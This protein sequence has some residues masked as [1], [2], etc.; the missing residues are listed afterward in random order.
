LARPPDASAV[1]DDPGLADLLVIAAEPAW[2]ATNMLESQR[3]PSAR[4]MD[5]SDLSSEHC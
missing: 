1:P 3:G 4:R 5:L 2:A